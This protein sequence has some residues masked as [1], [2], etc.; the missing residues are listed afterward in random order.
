M[1]WNHLIHT[2]G[3]VL[4]VISG[5]LAITAAVS[6]GY[7]DGD[8]AAFL[9]TGAIATV[10]GGAALRFTRVRADLSIREGYAVVS[11]SWVAIGLIGALPYLLTGTI[12]NPVA[13]IFESVSGFTTTG[14]TVFS[15]IESLPHGILLWRS[16]TQWLGGMG[17]ILLG[18]AIL[19]FLGVGGMHLF[20]A[21]VP[22]P[23]TERLTP[24]IAQTAKVLWYVYGGLTV[25]LTALLLLGGMGPFDAVNHALTTMPTGGFS[26]KNASIAA[27]DSPWIQWVII[28]FMYLAGV[29]FILHF[30]AVTSRPGPSAYTSSAEWCFYTGA[31]LVAS[32]LVLVPLLRQG[33][34]VEL[35]IERAIR[36]VVFQVVSLTTTTGY[37]SA[38]YGLWP[39][40]TQLVLIGMMFMGGMA[41]STGG[42]IKVMRIHVLFKQAAAELRRSLHPHAVVVTRLGPR[43]IETPILLNILGFVL[44]F[45]AIF[46]AGVVALA[47]LGH[48]LATAVGASVATLA[49]I[50]PGVGSVGPVDN[51]GWMDSWS[52]G[53][54]IVLMIVGRLEIFTVL[55]LLHPGLWRR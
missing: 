21:E 30:R 20:R 13:A 53:L 7:G 41:G 54:L 25:A 50:G 10:L 12:T 44:L 18:V 36:D 16:I 29:N 37:V 47:F 8:A 39:L 23:T 3:L 28:V 55:L 17:I 19:P 31:I 4:L 43:A 9:V 45:L 40:G 38:D 27:F 1:R 52:H 24:R 42:G 49:N 14:A 6:W 11:L 26:P 35:G 2:V 33:G 46:A 34:Y 51:F 32:A 5:P 48:D 22:G 15:D